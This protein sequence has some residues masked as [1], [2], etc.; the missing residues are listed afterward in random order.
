M[1]VIRPNS[2]S[3]IT[4]ITAQA[5]EI[6]VFKS[7]GTLAGLSLNGVNVNTTAGIS[8]YAALNVTG[9]VSVG[10]TLTYQD[11]T[12]VDAVGLITARA[13][14]NV[15]GGQLDVGSN[16]KLGNA[17]VI[18][19]TSF[20]GSGA[21]LT[22]IAGGVTSDA[23]RNTIGGSNSGDSFDGT[24]AT[25]NTLLGYDSGTAI[26]TGD[27]NT[28]IGS[29]AGDSVTTSANITAIGYYAASTVSTQ[30][31]YT[32]ITAVGSG[33]CKTSV[34]VRNTVVGF[35]ALK[36]GSSAAYN[37]ILGNEAAVSSD[38]SRN[39]VI[40]DT[41]HKYGTSSSSY[42]VVLGIN[43]FVGSNSNHTSSH[44]ISIGYDSMYNGSRTT[45][46]GNVAIGSSS[47]KTLTTGNNNIIIGNSAEPTSA[48]TSNEIT[49]GGANITK[50]RIPG[51]NFTNDNGKMGLGTNNPTKKLTIQAGS[52]NTD[53]ALFTGNDLNRGL[54]IST[55]AA[56]SQND[57]G[58]VY[59]A[60]GQ[61]GGSYLG[62]HIFKTNNTE[63]LR[64]TS[65]GTIRQTGGDL[66]IDNTNN[67]YGGLRIVDDSGGDYTVN[68]ITGRNQG[69]T[70]HVFKRGGRVQ[71]QSPWTN[72][73]G[74]IEI[75]RISRGGI[76][77]GGDTAAANT[78]DD[79]EEGSWTPACNV[80]SVSVAD[81][82]TYRKI[83]GLVHL[84]VLLYNFSNTSSSSSVLIT[85]V[86]YSSSGQNVGTV[87]LR[88]TTSGGKG[89]VCTIGDSATNTI[90]IQ[91]HSDGNDMGQALRYSD[92][93]HSTPYMNL[94]ITYQTNS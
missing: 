51:L 52:N 85:G 16:I 47:G 69:A 57:M 90:N 26:T 9:N 19:A 81:G 72:S 32:G 79:Y 40:G 36:N 42:N 45:A 91:R 21:N 15:S 67:G 22:V 33:A 1:T 75:A 46:Y 28:L 88:R 53:I 44:S 87:W 49:L 6:N 18:T 5:N 82:G 43:A 64:I 34:G 25:D 73:G 74:D 3:G 31:V 24:N 78:L 55:I 61:H 62:E 48:T 14:V 30:S 39:V 93:A 56:N 29:Y 89:W 2:I 70:A 94:T 41:A 80:G 27:K 84:T 37:C 54:L 50:F 7:D 38:G 66:I 4:S 12:N 20:V 17:G 68:Y 60:H 8:T 59:H 92:F 65:G 11:V 23:Q 77:F 76:A 10:G 86:P 58:V 83:G 71:N 35:D 13:G 63:R